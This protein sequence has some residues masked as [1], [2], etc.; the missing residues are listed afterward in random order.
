MKLNW[1]IIKYLF[2]DNEI[3]L[4]K[5]DVTEANTII[6]D[7]LKEIEMYQEDLTEAKKEI[8]ELLSELEQEGNNNELEQYWNNKYAKGEVYYAGR[9]GIRMDVRQFINENDYG[10]PTVNGS[11]NDA[12]ANN[13]LKW[14]KNN[15]RYTLSDETNGEFWKYSWETLNKKR[16]DCEDGAILMMNIMIKSGIPYWRIRLNAGDVEGGGHAYITYLRESDNEWYILDWCYWYNESVNFKKTWNKAKKYFGIWFSWNKK[17]SFN[18]T[19]F[20]VIN[21]E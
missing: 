13:A 8:K 12:K 7:L 6:N 5:E 21:N 1:Y 19:D 18:E 16:G 11:N 10:I 20:T 17:Y 3:L 9:E 15:I 4:L 2:N 14:V